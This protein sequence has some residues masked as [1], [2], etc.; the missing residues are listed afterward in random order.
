MTLG[1]EIK[2]P[3]LARTNGARMGHPKE[4]GRW[5]RAAE[6]STQ[7]KRE[8]GEDGVDDGGVQ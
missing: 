1:R 4:K 5:L 2:N 3:T 6:N 7:E 8:E